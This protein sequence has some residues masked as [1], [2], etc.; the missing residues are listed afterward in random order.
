MIRPPTRRRFLALAGSAVA[1]PALLREGYAQAPQVTLQDAPLPAAGLERARQVPGALGQKVGQE[2]GGTD[3]DRHLPLDAARRH[4]AAALRSG[5]RRRRRPR[6]DAARQHARPLP[7]H[8]RCSSCPS[9]RTAR[10]VVNAKASRSSPRRTSRTS[11]SEV[12]PI[13]FW[14]HDH[15]LVHAN[16]PVKTL[17]DLKGLKLRFPTRLAG[18]ALRALGATAIGMPVPQ[19]PESWRSGSSTAPWCRGRW[20]RRSRC[21]SSSSTTPRSRARRPSTPRPSCSR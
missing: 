5:P 21:T 20:C 10:R 6:L 1:A 17:E 7:G 18:E 16:K 19:V 11:S 8:A 12:H 13:C 2:S 15:G 9:C 4:A 3:Q 14:A